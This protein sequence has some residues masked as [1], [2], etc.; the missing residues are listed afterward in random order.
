MIPPGRC[1]SGVVARCVLLALLAVH[2]VPADANGQ[3]ADTTASPLLTLRTGLPIR[4]VSPSLGLSGD[5]S[6]LRTSRDTVVVVGRFDER[7]VPRASIT[8]LDVY[9]GRTSRGG[10]VRGAKIGAVVGLVNALLCA[11]TCVPDERNKALMFSV[12]AFGLAGG[13]IGALFRGGSYTRLIPVENG[14]P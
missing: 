2:V 7:A 8:R 3:D 10:V 1:R 11:A 9:S 13:A 12:P 14:A 6:V 5:M 4:L